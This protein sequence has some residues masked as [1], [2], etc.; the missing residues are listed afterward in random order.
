MLDAAPWP[1]PLAAVSPPGSLIYG[2]ATTGIAD[3]GETDSFLI[4]LQAG[5]QAAFRFTPPVSGWIG[6]ITVSGPGGVVADTGALTAS[7]SDIVVEGVP[8]SDAGTYSF[9]VNSTSAV[10]ESYDVALTLN[11]GI[12]NE[13]YDDG[14]NDT[15]A[16][17]ENIDS[18]AF[19]LPKAGGDRLAVVGVL[20]G[21]PD[22]FSFTLLAGQPASIMLT[23]TQGESSPGDFSLEL[24]SADGTL[25]AS[26]LSDADNTD[27][28]IT[29][30]VAP[31]AG[32]YY[33]RV[34]GNATS[35]YSLVVTRSLEF[36][37]EP[38]DDVGAAQDLKNAIA[39]LTSLDGDGASAVIDFEQL[40]HVDGGTANHGR[41][42]QEDGFVLTTS[43]FNGFASFGTFEGRF[44]GSTALFNSTVDGVTVLAAIDGSAFTLESIDIAELNGHSVTSV[45]F[46]ATFEGGGT[47]TETIQ[48]DGVA[49]APETFVF[50]GFKNVTS[51]SWVQVSPY[52]QF[53]NIVLGTP[54][55]VFSFAV[56]AGDNLT[57]TSSTP[58]DGGDE[59]N[60]DLDPILELYDPSGTLVA[61]NN[62]GAADGKNALINHVTEATGRYEVRVGSVTG[63]GEVV[64][65][66]D[67]ATG[68]TSMP[69]IATPLN[70]ADGTTVAEFPGTID[71]QFTAG[72]LLSEL[73]AGDLT[74]NGMPANGVV[75]VDGRTVQFDVATLESGDIS[76]DVVL[77]AG[78]VQGL[79]G[80]TNVLL[81]LSFTLD[82]TGPTVVATSHAMGDVIGPGPL[83]FHA[84][85]SEDIVT[86]DLGSEDV[87]LVA[88]FSGN[89]IAPL[90]FSYDEPT[91][92]VTVEFPH[93]I[94][95]E[96]TLELLSGAGAF[97]DL[98]GNP[99]NGGP[100]FP[101]PSGQGDPAGDDFT[102]DFVVDTGTEAYPTPL[103]PKLPLGSLIYDPIQT[104]AFDTLGDLDS[105]TIDLDAG[106]TATIVLR[107]LDPSVQASLE[108]FDELNAS[109]ASAAAASA[110]DNVVLQ[111]APVTGAGIYRIDA[112]S[113]AGTGLYELQVVLN[114]AVEIESYSGPTNDVMS[115]AQD[116]T[117]SFI[118]LLGTAERGAVLG[119]LPAESGI[120]I[121]DDGF[122]DGVLDARWSIMSSAAEGSHGLGTSYA[123]T[124]YSLDQI[125]DTAA[126]EDILQE[127]VWTVDL[128]GV[129]QAELRFLARDYATA[130]P[131]AGPYSGSFNADGV[132]ISADGITWYPVYDSPTN[133]SF[134]YTQHLIDLTDAAASAGITLGAGF[135]IKFQQY[136]PLGQAG[137]RIWDNVTIF[138]PAPAE[139]WYQFSL[140]GG[141]VV[142]IALAEQTAHNVAV[143]ELYDGSGNLL[144]MSGD[145]GINTTALLTDFVA[146]ASAQYFVRVMGAAPSESTDY[147][148]ML[149][150][151]AA[152]DREPNDGAAPDG[153][154]ITHS[155]AVLAFIEDGTSDYYQIEVNAG[156][157]LTITTAT[158]AGGTGEFI[159]DVDPKIELFDPDGTLVGSADNEAGDGRNVMLAHMA[160]LTGT[161]SVRVLSATG[162]SGEVA[163]RIEGNTGAAPLF[164]VASTDPADEDRFAVAPTSFTVTFSNQVLL[165]SLERA[166][167]KINGADAVGLTVLNSN[168]VHFDLPALVEGPYVVTIAAGSIQSLSGQPLE[169]FSSQFVVDQTGP[170]IASLSVQEGDVLNS[171]DLS[172]EVLFDESLS[173][174]DLDDGDFELFGQSSGQVFS[175]DT[176]GFDSQTD[177]L[178]I[179][180]VGLPEDSY[181]LSLFSGDGRIEDL[182]GNDLDGEPL[183][184]PIPPGES[185]DGIPG[186]DFTVNFQLDE[187]VGMFPVPLTGRVPLGSLIYGDLHSGQLATPGDVDTF[188]I[189]L[190]PEQTASVVLR[191]LDPSI[192]AE[193]TLID[194]LDVVVGTSTAGSPGET[195]AIQ[196]MPIT[197]SGT[198]RIEVK[199]LAGMGDY[200]VELIL[201]ASLEEELLGSSTND[202]LATSQDITTSSL[203]VSPDSDRLAVVGQLDGSTDWF[204]FELTAG[205]P[206]TIVVAGEVSED[207]TLQLFADDGTL[208]AIGDASN[209]S[210]THHITNFIASSNGVY[211]ATVSGIEP[212][213]YGLVIV[214]NGTFGLEFDS[215]EVQALGGSQYVLGQLGRGG[216]GLG[217]GFAYVRSTVGRPWG[218]STP[219]Q[220]MDAAF[221]AG[222]WE[223]LRF[224]T[225]DPAAL[226]S[227]QYSFVY[228]EGSDSNANELEAFL[229]DNLSIIESFVN[230]GGAVFIN[231]APNEGNGM[232]FGFG[233]VELV[234]SDTTGT[235]GAVVTDHPIF[236]GP[237]TPVIATYSGNSFGHATVTGGGITSLVV[238]TSDSGVVLAELEWGA[239]LVLFGGMTTTNYHSPQPQAFNLRANTLV[240]AASNAGDGLDEYTV[241]LDVGDTLTV[242][243][244]TPADGA[245]EFINTLDPVLEILDPMEV[246]VATDSNS[247]AD[248]RNAMVTYMATGAGLHRIRITAENDTLGEYVLSVT[249]ADGTTIPLEVL[250]SSPSDQSLLNSYPTSYLVSFSDTLL[251][252]SVDAEDFT[253]GGVP[254]DSVTIVDGRTL[255]F[256]I[257]SANHG[258]GLYEVVIAAG[259][260]TSVSGA[261][262]EEFVATFDSDATVPFV[263]ASSILEGD[264]TR[265]GAFT[266]QV[267]FNETLALTDIGAED[268]L[269]VNNTDGSMYNP[270]AFD[271]GAPLVQGVSATASSQLDLNVSGFNRPVGNLVDGL[272]R[273]TTTPDGNPGEQAGMWESVGSGFVANDDLD[274]QVTFDLG[275]TKR[276]DHLL[277]YNYNTPSFLGRGVE[278]VEIL[279]SND[280][281]ASDTRSAGVFSLIQGS[282]DATNPAQRVELDGI[283]G[284]F[285]R[286]DILSNHNGAVFPSAPNDVDFNFVGLTEV[287][288]FASPLGSNLDRSATIAF[289]NVTEG[290]YT[291][292]L[293]SAADGF[294]DR[295]DNV[296]DGA[297]SFPLPSGDGTPGDDFVVHFTVDVG[298]DPLSAPLDPKAPIGSLIFD[299]PQSGLFGAAEDVDTFTVDLDANQTLSLALTPLDPSIQ[300]S[301]RLLT[302]DGTPIASSQAA[303]A[304]EPVLVQTA[305]VLT[306]GTYQLA[307]ESLDGAGAYELVIV[308]NAAVE[309]ESLGL[310]ANDDLGTA[311]SLD[312]SSVPLQADADR[313][314]ALGTLDGTDDFFSFTLDAG[315]LASI[316]ATAQDESAINLELLGTAGELLAIGADTNNTSAAIDGFFAP[317]AGTYYAKVMGAAGERYTLMIT[318]EAQFEAE[319]NDSLSDAKRLIW[320]PAGTS[321]YVAQAL[322]A[323]SEQVRSIDPDNYAE[324]SDLSN[325][326]PGV[327]LSVVASNGATPTGETV[328]SATASGFAAS[329]GS[330][331]FARGGSQSWNSSSNWLRADFSI[332]VSEVSI[333][334]IGN[335]SFDPGILRAYNA[336]GVL[337]EE[338]RGF[339][340]SPGNPQHLSITR[341]Q[342][343]IAYI[344]AAGIGGDTAALDN[345][346][347][348][349]DASDAYLLSLAEGD[350]VELT[351]DTPY[352]APDQ[353]INDFDPKLELYDADGFLVAVDENSAVDGRNARIVYTVPAGGTGDYV[354]QVKGA[355]RG[356]YSVLAN[357]STAEVAF[358]TPPEVVSSIPAMG[359]AVATAPAVL[360]V[361]FN[362]PVRADSVDVGDVVFANAA[363]SVNS[364][365]LIDAYTV[366]YEISVPDMEETFDYAVVAGAVTD[367]QGSPSLEY[368]S[369][370]GIDQTGLR[371]VAT[372]PAMQ[373][374]APFNQLTFVFSEAIA[375]DSVDTDDITSF[376]GPGGVS[377]LASITGVDVD[378][379]QV[380]VS[381]DDQ[382]T[383]GTYTMTI[384]PMITDL[385]GNLMDQ[386]DDGAEGQPDDIY[387]ATVDLQS[388]DVVV[389]TINV[390]T[391]A[392]FGQT[393]DIDWSVRNAGT[394]PAV[395][396]WSDRVY[397][398]A[399][400]NL[401]SDDVELLTLPA[402]TVPLS[403]GGSYTTPTT[404]VTLPLNAELPAGTYFIIVL[405]DGLH[406][407]PET[408]ETNNFEVSE[409]IS[410]TIPDLPDLVVSDIS[411][412]LEALSGQD[413]PISWTITNQGSGDAVG[414]FRD[415]LFLSSDAFVGSDQFFGEFEL[416]G[417]IP[418]GGSITRTQTIT[419]PINLGTDRYVIVRTDIDDQ[420]FEFD[421][422]ANNVTVDDVPIDIELAPFPNLQVAEVIAPPS[423][424]SGQDVTV[425][426]I[427]T[428]VG[429]GATSAP[430]W[431]DRVYLSFDQNLDGTDTFLGDANNPSFLNVGDSYR[432]NLTA[433]LP[434][435]LDD[436]Y[437]FIIVTDIA[438]Q[439]LEF[440]A[441][442]DNVGVGGPTEIQLPDL[443]DL[444]VASVQAPSI[445]F[446]GQVVSV[447]WTVENRGDGNTR[448]SFWRDRVYL[449]TDMV[450]G[451][452]DVLL[453]TSNHSGALAPSEMY[454]SSAEV[455]LP[456]GIDGDYYV[457]VCT[458]V[459][460]EV[461]EHVFESNNCTAS[462]P[463][464]DVRLS[465]PPDLEVTQIN[466]PL[467]ATASRAFT[468]DYRV[469]NN[470]SDRT[471]NSSWNDRLYVS[472]DAVFDAATDT[473]LQSRTHAGAL[474]PSQGYDASFSATLPDNLVGTYYV[475]VVTD[476]ANIVFEQNNDNNV[477]QA[478]QPVTISSEPADLNVVIFDAQ[479]D[480]EAGGSVLVDWSVQNIGVGDTAVAT[481]YDR[482]YLSSN[483]VLDSG[484]LVLST[485][486]HDG[487]LNPTESYHVGNH[488]VQIPFSTVPGSYYLFLTTDYDNRVFEAG[489]EGNNTS[490]AVPIEIT[491][492][493][494]DL[495]VTSVTA[496][497]AAAS[498]TQLDV[499]WTVEN[500]S[501]APT[502]ANYWYDDV[503]LSSDQTI[504]GGDTYLGRVQHSNVLPGGGA[505]TTTRS[506]DLPIN[507]SGEFFVL[508]RTDANNRVV[509]EGA[510]GNND[511]AS[512]STTT[513]TLSPTPDMIVTN[514]DAPTEA[515]SGQP[516]SLTWTVQNAGAADASGRWYDAVYLSLDQIF[517]RNDDIVLGTQASPNFGQ[518]RY[519]FVPVGEDYTQTGSFVIPNGLS[520]PFWV[521][522]VT[523]SNDRLYER[524]AEGNNVGLDPLSMHVNLTPPADFVVG[525]ITVPAN[526]IPGQQATIEYTVVNNGVNAARGTWVDSVYLSADETWDIN[527]ALVGRV[528]NI[529]FDIPGGGGSY[530]QMLTA[531][532]PGVL[533]GD[534]HVIIRSD[535]LNRI[536]ESDETNNIGVSLDRAALDFAELELGIATAGE[537]ARGQAAYY[538][539]DVPAGE[540]LSINFDSLAGDGFNE[541]YLAFDRVPSRSNF[542][543][544]SIEP[545]EVDQRAIVPS[546]QAGTYFVL[547]YAN[548]LPAGPQQYDITAE[549][550][551]FEVFDTNYG[552]GGNAG[553][554]TIEINGAK[555]DR[556][557]TARLTTAEG[558]DLP[559]VQSFPISPAKV[560]VTFDLSGLDP[561]RYDVVVERPTSGDEITI[562]NGI[563]VALGGGGTNQPSLDIPDAVRRPFFDPATHFNF[564][565]R[566]GNDGIND[567][568]APLLLVESTASISR[569]IETI[570]SNVSS[571]EPP[572]GG[573]PVTFLEGRSLVLLGVSESDGPPGIIMPRDTVEIPFYGLIDPNPDSIV[574]SVDR[575]GMDQLGSPFPWESYRE[576]LRDGQP[577]FDAVFDELANSF[578]TWED[579]LEM[580]AGNANLIT[581]DFGRPDLLTDLLRLQLRFERADISNSI[582]GQVFAASFDV[583]IAR[584]SVLAANQLS[585]QKYFTTTLQDGTFVFP[586]L[587]SGQYEIASVPTNDRTAAVEIVQL[588][589][590]D[591]V[592]GLVLEPR[593]RVNLEARVVHAETG[594]PIANVEIILSQ[595]GTQF[596]VRAVTDIDGRFSLIGIPEGTYQVVPEDS[597]IAANGNDSIAV[598]MNGSATIELLES[599]AL[600]GEVKDEAGV[601]VTGAV[602]W[603]VGDDGETFV[604]ST[605][606]LGVF[607]LRQLPPDTYLLTLYTDGFVSTEIS[608]LQ[609]ASGETTDIGIVTLTTGGSVDVT[610]TR[611]DDGELTSDAEVVATNQT[612][613]EHRTGV[614]DNAGHVVISGLAE[615]TWSV[616]VIHSNFVDAPG[617]TATIAGTSSE[618][619]TFSLDTGTRVSGSVV[620]QDRLP[621]AATAISLFGDGGELSHR[622]TMTDELG[623]FTVVGLDV[624]TYTLVAE[625][626]GFGL[627]TH[628]ITVSSK[629]DAITELEFALRE[630]ATLSGQV[631]DDHGDGVSGAFLRIDRGGSVVST[632][633]TDANGGFAIERLSPGYYLIQ[634]S[635]D[636]FAGESVVI[637]VEEGAGNAARD[638]TLVRLPASNAVAG[639]IFQN[640]GVTPVQD[641]HARF[642]DGGDLIA[643][644]SSAADGTYLVDLPKGS[645]LDVAVSHS[646]LMFASTQILVES[647][648]QTFNVNAA[649]SSITGTIT[650]DAG[651]PVTGAD[652][653]LVSTPSGSQRA[654]AISVFSDELG[655]FEFPAVVQGEHDV[656][657]SADGFVTAVSAV[658]VP[659]NENVNAVI[660]LQDGQILQGTVSSVET[661][662]PLE[663]VEVV[664]LDPESFQ[665]ISATTTDDAGRYELAGLPSGQVIID[666]RGGQTASI[667]V[668][669]TLPNDNSVDAQLALAPAHKL[670][671]QAVAFVSG[672]PLIGALV[673]ARRVDG[674]APLLPVTT[675]TSGRFEFGAVPSGTYEV[676]VIFGTEVVRDSIVLDSDVDIVLTVVGI[677]ATESVQSNGLKERDTSD[678]NLQ[679]PARVREIR[680][681]GIRGPADLPS[682]E[683]NAL[684]N[685]AMA[686]EL[687]M[688]A[689]LPDV[690]D[691]ESRLL[692]ELLSFDLNDP[693][694]DEI[695]RTTLE[696]Q[697]NALANTNE[698]LL[699]ASESVRSQ[700]KA[701]QDIQ[702]EIKNLRVLQRDVLLTGAYKAAMDVVFELLNAEKAELVYDL[703]AGWVTGGDPQDKVE[704]ITSDIAGILAN[705]NP[706]INLAT[707][708]AE[709]GRLLTKAASQAAQLSQQ[710]AVLAQTV[711]DQAPPFFKSVDALNELLNE[712][713]RQLKLLMNN[714]ERFLNMGPMATGDGP[715][716]IVKG[717]TVQIPVGLLLAN[718]EDVEGDTLTIQSVTSIAPFGQIGLAL[719]FITIV[720]PTDEELDAIGQA[721]VAGTSFTYTVADGKG[722]TDT[723]AVTLIFVDSCPIDPITGEKDCFD[724]NMNGDEESDENDENGGD[725]GGDDGGG[726]GGDGSDDSENTDKQGSYDPNDILGP[727]GFGPERW[728][729]AD[730][731]LNYT[732]RFENDPELATAPAQVVRIT[733]QLDADLDFRT[734]R[735]GDFAIGATV[736]DVPDNR[737][738]YADRI[739]LTDELGV[740]VDVVAGIDVATG[741]AFW[742]FSAIDPNTGEAPTDAL[743]GLLP[744]NLTSP[745]GEGFVTYSVR[746]RGDAETGDVIDATA[747]IIFDV[748]EPIDTPPIF[749][750]LDADDPVSAVDALPSNVATTTFDV[751]WSGV[752]VEG[753]SGLAGFDVYVS[754]NGGPFELF[755]AGTTLTTAPFVGE[756]GTQ[757]EFYSVARDNA[758]NVEDAPGTLDAVTTTPAPPDPV[759][760][761]VTSAVV[762]DGQ[763]QRS[764]VDQLVL[765]FS[766]EVNLADLIADGSITNAI[767]L[768]NLGVDVDNDADEVVTLTD[769]QFEYVYDDVSG[770]SRLTWSLDEFGG[771]NSSL[772]DGYYEFVIDASIV[773][774]LAGNPFDG[775]GDETGGD[776]YVLNFHRLV[777]DS[778]GD[779]VVDSLDMD[780]VNNAL[781][782]QPASATWDVNADLD[783]D[784][785]VTVRDRVIVGRSS[786]R[787]IFPSQATPAAVEVVENDFNGDGTVDGLDYLVWVSEFG[788][789]TATGTVL[790]D[791]DVSGVIDGLDYLAWAG[792]FASSIVGTGAL[793]GAGAGLS[794]LENRG[795]TIGQR[796]ET[797]VASVKSPNG[798]DAA[799]LAAHDSVF[800]TDVEDDEFELF[801]VPD[802]SGE[803]ADFDDVFDDVE[804]LDD[805]LPGARIDKKR[806]R[807]E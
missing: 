153:Q 511:G 25:L 504:S 335:D 373:A 23:G 339:S 166:D 551:E 546:T 666:F 219:E 562:P 723:A 480:A 383:F 21:T 269:L 548:D 715:F 223:D 336:S 105:Y 83:S 585:G 555:F 439:V 255:Q 63:A 429:T 494:A 307:V 505:Y 315:Q 743:V 490:S 547:V 499:T 151:N 117:S 183:S 100:S 599:G 603:A 746:P 54:D 662:T 22:F 699:A 350:V 460:D 5:Q 806:F 243:T 292:T 233:G 521:F 417:T 320:Q 465:P 689:D 759:P 108:L 589:E 749:N 323:L 404:T 298:V 261:P 454:Q 640:D 87:R 334:V 563:E 636:G 744:P 140:D 71:L 240:Y 172:I 693:K 741:E 466:A 561:G 212:Q 525:S 786:G 343:D 252:T 580:L 552:R 197:S 784:N 274:P 776:N 247:A 39:V 167:L 489:V 805:L 694:L 229:G 265:P 369:S 529:G 282:G 775:D 207:L 581:P 159:N 410:I 797:L 710:G 348:E 602:V 437:Y 104:S 704:E 592:Q 273:G 641:A 328:R 272:G 473:L 238:D 569:N 617:Q 194:P 577:D 163:L 568:L 708:I 522:V 310:G 760:P 312:G 119:T 349:G 626:D 792:N 586:K 92:V 487:L 419:L 530:S 789:T 257:T 459:F 36:G 502:N 673:V 651:M 121:F 237:L 690:K 171:G 201:N 180:F 793:N 49:F 782:A 393:I 154:D 462:D 80:T 478:N 395:E 609:V 732:I 498:G 691:F 716:N 402:V 263:V 416:T 534:Y 794:S 447:D 676:V 754:A 645:T 711:I 450:L 724:D 165:T 574:T 380:T 523:D 579:A 78:V 785:R 144:A 646:L 91:R 161:Y 45:T 260:L 656:V 149:T 678:T 730:Q 598:G 661:G 634:V 807:I 464:T 482:V 266:Y 735:V 750:T 175:P 752:D 19:D 43:G 584:V 451:Q 344:L 426:W 736:V 637:L 211:Y 713:E 184:F 481:W 203:T 734:F 202:E 620:D 62:N 101:L 763:T 597:F 4:D 185:G 600:I 788:R 236:L 458:D 632:T 457:I 717:T 434:N 463:V 3:A 9:D 692:D 696:A 118:T 664:V 74:V 587:P 11:A 515:F 510:D 751:S 113:I 169:A 601:E 46:T 359:Q 467:A 472:P 706:L 415:Q 697:I 739:D 476:F 765:E 635:A 509:E 376:M 245:F 432:N 293:R 595:I 264:T 300:A 421:G 400:S 536:P 156:D 566:F 654:S 781:G 262:A 360:D 190:D 659:D 762:Q 479:G 658:T 30:F 73:E 542:D 615:G 516:F 533:P 764:Y 319:P 50:E 508:V 524:G 143:F 123:F 672:R 362:E 226:F 95:G 322:G 491:R 230:A 484:D 613:F 81:G 291:L 528:T 611:S 444:V 394:D 340:T 607:N 249:G 761:T 384:G 553:N 671:G 214:R 606:A 801:S 107:P 288:L 725:D 35:E 234:Y 591:R 110:G 75:V 150:K 351:T 435:G 475:F 655:G 582:S 52:H 89:V 326:I 758:G 639:S 51:V 423:A 294:R 440:E 573:R 296:L 461:F 663:N 631:L 448:S 128:S 726:D 770:V 740:L 162:T 774:D 531:P 114:A 387:T 254:A 650:D 449:S 157:N 799:V 284:R 192:E 53:D 537:L 115:D 17:A 623:Q 507:L 327:T 132:S 414:T 497:A 378:G 311:Q 130:N 682:A 526:G 583:D 470:G 251:L 42:Y 341:G 7:G 593:L 381:F 766:E 677:T 405:T 783:R 665:R 26:G 146:P 332:A 127:A 210:E 366:R 545:F 412:P 424:F 14:N 747:T 79:D 492:Q 427:V 18:T 590:G 572:V 618:V 199:A 532:L 420:I 198:Y 164:A 390:P 204:Q 541:V 738:F 290:D 195:I 44:T 707:V 61:A 222:N 695:E 187:T 737:A 301:V 125:V 712:A 596:I 289:G 41:S 250:G 616:E 329:T 576:R 126:S 134:V 96:Y 567:A 368:L 779:G 621:V 24:Y 321:E 47:A 798:L 66:V 270:T 258:D 352:A 120:V 363:V 628:A 124:G 425:E 612:T 559:A 742:E 413:I 372:N 653:T 614:T 564:F 286:L 780:L 122:D 244:A 316:A 379:S 56:E 430:T 560:F 224:E 397:L 627:A 729:Q 246:V 142:T 519:S 594:A 388:P 667:R 271:F 182:V 357:R 57:I 135:Q 790:S 756:Y 82:T 275:E 773:T 721:D 345:L 76:Y 787:Q 442:D 309:E 800:E 753:G 189:D 86:S 403:A 178:S 469:E 346:V 535:I 32:T 94:D 278:E 48:I 99:L 622:R 200:E 170:R 225:V 325:V 755:L 769:A 147:S 248:G 565:V 638:V 347:V 649:S 433:R 324:G 98:V 644:A 196:S 31:I 399:D 131:F 455:T 488:L 543:F 605:D 629:L 575:L 496:P 453:A 446:S 28:Y 16:D 27:Q 642:Y 501:G 176:F 283:E 428:N 102:V 680:L 539:V 67:G 679:A 90:S 527:D 306:A 177:T 97:R 227:S 231:T 215:G 84:T 38:N 337:L 191:T 771:T 88:N 714:K 688:P 280:D 538:K 705:T 8:I 674:Q 571:E 407:Q 116:V 578:P 216:G 303:T 232:S 657:V 188:T 456:V 338:V 687:P 279:V 570:P 220:A 471:P 239:G 364:A 727:D 330:R 268:V 681:N 514:V 333:D 468:V 718:D 308:L 93:L 556:T 179:D 313:L 353:P 652:I 452:D 2:T 69:L 253:V 554:L 431:R 287:E 748:N 6:S 155:S 141:D 660:T 370:F 60:N 65:V 361:S 702:D 483:S 558:I 15:L 276:I 281:F 795:T 518:E 40:Q 389:D 20:A 103:T 520:G 436:D 256:D 356:S 772:A 517:D 796:T 354:L 406:E 557:V 208:L 608:A 386:I 160:G 396:G 68:P 709:V 804:S 217:T 12:E 630:G 34:D 241:Y 686:I 133:T 267:E 669:V 318:R 145:G 317:V 683:R 382:N 409:A 206:T 137:W 259:T 495:Q 173:T 129:S 13:S 64:I 398:S 377:L 438:G 513:V 443:P 302:L 314:G 411:A 728:V 500:L 375:P 685:E 136:T 633:I 610:V 550:L 604:T 221:G 722:L 643:V 355:N 367:L 408:N 371:V 72:L 174:Q 624:G 109:V 158:P 277:L 719:D 10:G 625:R 70:V 791:A 299:P 647:T 365:T 59:P 139:D 342:A 486:R 85:L 441:E 242:A 745:E 138:E 305:P 331:L 731:L 392:V 186:G 503:Y 757:Y 701:L 485:V 733:E 77:A 549:L 684:M 391:S 385:V 213:R 37:L 228:L 358:D 209:T 374:S 668:N 218:S 675:D 148:L 193:M 777:G 401:D 619:L 235:A 767:T 506:L 803:S 111:V 477:A 295:R 512:S 33:A 544:A 1:L 540:T 152:F 29:G 205:E 422:E 168:T 802:L 297:P 493:T 588:N 304:G 703:F 778:T 181:T 58:L 418:A 106:Q 670:S 445:A 768:T 698:Q 720:A 700:L 474:D 55:D 285:V 112:A 648:P